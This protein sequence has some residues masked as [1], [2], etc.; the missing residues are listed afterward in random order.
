[1]AFWT[2]PEFEHTRQPCCGAKDGP[3]LAQGGGI[4]EKDSHTHHTKQRGR[5]IVVELTKKTA[6]EG[7]LQTG[8]KG[9]SSM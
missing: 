7:V 1:M 2:P 8:D 6:N 9:K 3:K 5:Q 4:K